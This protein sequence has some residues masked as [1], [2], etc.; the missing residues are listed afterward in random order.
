MDNIL[1]KGKVVRDKILNA[2]PMQNIKNSISLKNVIILVIIV[3]LFI[4]GG[5][6]AYNNYVKPGMDKKYVDNSEFLPKDQIAE[7]TADMF[8]FYTDW[9][10]HSKKA[11]PEWNLFKTNIGN[12]KVNGYSINFYE[13]DCDKNTEMADKYKVTEY[14]TVKLAFDNQIVEYDAKPNSVTLSEFANTVLPDKT[15]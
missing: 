11:T 6:Y 10:P 1:T 13:I 5:V 15:Q 9:C 14:P 3:G 7:N 4:F 12:S 2:I 8:Y